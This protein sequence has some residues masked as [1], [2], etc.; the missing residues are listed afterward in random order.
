MKS[1]TSSIAQAVAG[2]SLDGFREKYIKEHPQGETL[3]ADNIRQAFA[4]YNRYCRKFR[5]NQPKPKT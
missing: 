2:L 4:E 3:T 5:R 1:V